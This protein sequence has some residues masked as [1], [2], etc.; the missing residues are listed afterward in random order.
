M[1]HILKDHVRNFQ[2]KTSPFEH[3]H[4]IIPTFPLFLIVLKLSLHIMV[5]WDREC[6]IGILKNV[7]MHNVNNKYIPTSFF[8]II[9][10]TSLFNNKKCIKNVI[11]NALHLLGFTVDSIHAHQIKGCTNHPPKMTNYY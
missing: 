7:G 4:Q 3:I 9:L 8:K 1:P 10:S 2:L 5:Y 6:S 11:T